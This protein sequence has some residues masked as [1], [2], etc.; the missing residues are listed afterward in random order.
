M[1]TEDYQ[2]AAVAFA[3]SNSEQHKNDSEKITIYPVGHGLI[4]H[5]YK[6]V[7]ESQSPFLLQQI[8]KKVFTNPKDVQ[9]NYLNIWQYAEFELTGLKLPS[10]KYWDKQETLFID[11]NHNYWRAFE[12]IPDSV[13]LTIAQKPSQAKAMAKTF[14]KFTSAFSNFNVDQLNTII[15]DFHNLTFRYEEMELAEK[16]ELYEQIAKA[17]PLLRELKARERYRHFYDI[18]TSSPE[19]PLRVMHH[20]AKIS[21][22]L[23]SKT[24]GRV[25]CPVDF[26]TVMPGYFFSDLGDMIRSTA[27]NFDENYLH[28]EKIR[29]RKNFYEAIISGYLFVMEKYLTDSEKKY[30]HYAGLMMIY[31]QA[32]RFLTDFMNGGIYY[33]VEYTGQNFDRALNQLTLLKRLEEFLKTEYDFKV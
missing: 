16:G 14:A 22:I 4:N 23:F 28:F 19:F 18:L 10:P 6:V 11:H 3:D 32:I 31:M 1:K 26:D 30:I 5:T 24:S 29:I 17:Q 2:E 21:N 25:I 13:T 12:Y 9:E 15:P 33:K 27:G 7:C 8:N 20:D